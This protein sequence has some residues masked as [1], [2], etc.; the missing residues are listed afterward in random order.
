MAP[1]VGRDTLQLGTLMTAYHG[2]RGDWKIDLSFVYMYHCVQKDD[3]SKNIPSRILCSW[4]RLTEW[5]KYRS[6]GAIAVD[7]SDWSVQTIPMTMLST[8]LMR[9]L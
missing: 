2:E 6:S 7:N 3:D 4:F 9:S 8:T 5:S 1:R